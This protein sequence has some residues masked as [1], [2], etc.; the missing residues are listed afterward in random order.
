[1]TRVLGLLYTWAVSKA[2]LTTYTYIPVTALIYLS[3]HLIYVS[4][5]LIYLSQ[6]GFDGCDC[7]DICVLVD[8]YHIW[9]QKAYVATLIN[10]C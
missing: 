2:V 5:S 1:M 7:L 4:K 10:V 8:Y 9:T 6:Q 3:H